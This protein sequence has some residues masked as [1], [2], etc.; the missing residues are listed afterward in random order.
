MEP[1]VGFWA[2]LVIQSL[3]IESFT[4]QWLQL[5]WHIISP[6]E[7]NDFHIKNGFLRRFVYKFYYSSLTDVLGLSTVLNAF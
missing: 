3:Q 1:I 5:L 7:I 4:V 6:I 2:H